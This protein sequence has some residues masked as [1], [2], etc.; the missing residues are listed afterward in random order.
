M[1][2][3]KHKF[4]D[5]YNIQMIYWMENL[6]QRCVFAVEFFNAVTNKESE[7][8]AFTQNCYGEMACL[9]W[10]HLFNKYE[11]DLHYKNLFGNDALIDLGKAFSYDKVRSRL[12]KSVSLSS[13]DYT[14]FR[15][16]VVHFRNKFVAHKDVSDKHVVFP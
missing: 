13:K 2:R 4:M 1:R 10:C 11:D 6:A 7:F 8:W 9:L 14:A 12:L 15:K 16:E 5:K 3:Q